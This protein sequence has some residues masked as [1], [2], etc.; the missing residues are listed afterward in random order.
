MS[1]WRSRS[2]E[3]STIVTLAPIPSAI[4][5][6]LVPTTPPPITTTFAPGH[7]RDAAQQRSAAAV[8]FLEVV[9]S[10]LD[11][12][13]PGNLAHRRQERQRAVF[14]LHRLI[15]NRLDLRFDQAW[16][17]TRSAAR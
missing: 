13:P 6:A 12:H 1:S 14:Q 5:A 3:R 8:R 4:C 16:S 15:R 17:V 2:S 9:G 7:A 11:R 10:D